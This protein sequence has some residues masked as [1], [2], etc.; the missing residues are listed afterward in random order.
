[1]WDLTAGDPLGGPLAGPAPADGRAVPVVN[2][3]RVAHRTHTSTAAPV[4]QVGA[5]ASS[6]G[7]H[8]W[9]MR[10]AVAPPANLCM[11]G[12]PG[13]MLK[14]L[15]MALAKLP[16]SWAFHRRHDGDA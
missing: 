5:V 10:P 11:S 2:R 6:F 8:P 16:S 1:V 15:E 13:S 12:G 4:A 14:G 7:I 3:R 9:G